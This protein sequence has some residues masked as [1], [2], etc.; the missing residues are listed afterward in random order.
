VG[1][2]RRQAAIVTAAGWREKSGEQGLNVAQV[3]TRCAEYLLNTGISGNADG[4]LLDF[5]ALLRAADQLTSEDSLALVID[6]R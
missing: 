3:N 6:S 1:A 4:G 5:P 2:I